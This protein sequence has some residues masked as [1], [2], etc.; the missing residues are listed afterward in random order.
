[1]TALLS[2]RALH[3]QYQE[4]DRKRQHGH[5]PKAVEI[6]KRRRLLL[7]QVFEFL[8][9]ELLGRDRIGGL[10]KEERPCVRE[11]GIG[12]CIVVLDVVLVYQLVLLLLS[13]LV[14]FCD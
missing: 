13:L 4:R 3:K 10:L 5:H 14:F 7:T 6:G 11:E 1:V 12:C 8:P 9:G 2:Y